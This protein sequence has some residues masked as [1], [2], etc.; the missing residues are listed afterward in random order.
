MTPISPRF[1]RR[2]A[3]TVAQVAALIAG[4]C[5]L[6]LP[7]RAAG[8]GPAA[9]ADQPA[10]APTLVLYSPASS[11]HAV[12]ADGDITASPANSPDPQAAA[13]AGQS[14]AAPIDNGFFH[15]LGRAYVA[16]WSGNGPATAIPQD[17]RRGTPA[18]I[19]SPPYPSSDW[20]IGGTPVIGAPDGQTY[21]FMQAVNENK[22]VNK[23]YGWIEVGA[24]GSTNNKTNAS[25]GIPANFPSAYDEYSNTIQLDQAA[26]YFE[27]LP[28]TAQTEHFDWGYRATAL[29]GVDYRF[30]TAKGMLSQQLLLKNAMYGFDP[31]MMY[32]DLYVPHVGQGMDIRIGRYISLPDIEAQ[33]APNNYTYS[34]S[35]LY[36]FDCYTQTG[37]NATVKVNGHWTV[38]AGLSPGCDVMPW[39]TDAK[40]TGNFCATY[41]WHN[42]GDALNTCANSVNDGKYAYNNLAAY[43]ETWYHRINANWHTDTEAWYQYMRQ[44]P[45]MYWY[46]GIDPATGI[47]Y[48][49]TATTPWPETTFQRPGEGAS[50]LNFGAV[51]EDPRL[52]AS[53]QQARCFAPEVAITNYV[54]HNFWHNTASLNIRNEFVDD[55]KGQRTGTPAKYEEHM[56]G[57][58][59]WAGSTITFRPELSYTHA[60]TKYGLTALNILP[61]AAVSNLEAVSQGA[62]PNPLGLGKNQALTLAADLIWHF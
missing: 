43:Y 50:T 24:N 30:T 48:A 5:I 59:F 7:A 32:I 54:E 28:N 55:I 51:C 34:H 16:D 38:Q 23:I 3:Q 52:P 61:G 2:S 47:Q 56:V 45:N 46:N 27:R 35:I 8:N 12:D 9:P 58:D 11:N 4:I 10:P 40:V 41:T 15:R 22:S 57:F 25:K 18:P 20:P 62:A 44:T 26:L 42:G 29:Y 14:P 19:F 6:A 60:Y 53:Q 13:A 49:P 21:P 39:T 31:V 37:I 36:T 1:V 33:L 17:P